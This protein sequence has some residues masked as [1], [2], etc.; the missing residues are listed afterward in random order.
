MATISNVR[1]AVDQQLQA[2][3]EPGW[4]RGFVNLL[5]NENRMW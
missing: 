4:R 3:N 2:I 1:A 5:S